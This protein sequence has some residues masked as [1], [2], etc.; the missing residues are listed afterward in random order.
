MTEAVLWD[1]PKSSA[2]YRVRIALNLAG[3][4]FRSEMVDLLQSTQKTEEH[5]NRSPQGLV[6]VLEIDGKRFTQSLAII[7]YLNDTGK[8]SVLPD[9]PAEKLRVRSL[10]YTLAVDVHPV[11]NLSV[12]TYA[13]KGKEPQRSEWMRRFTRPGLEAFEAQLAG[14]KQAPFC[15]GN[16][17]SLAD[18]C[19]IPQLYNAR[20][21]GVEIDDLSRILEVERVCASLD[22]FAKASP[23]VFAH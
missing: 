8:L 12:V 22:A 1:Y 2:S 16:T 7:E 6:P 18:I 15:V 23:E 4:S 17:P 13:T 10:A 3:I 5:I 20:R 19:L 21:W 14:F 11:C 9:D